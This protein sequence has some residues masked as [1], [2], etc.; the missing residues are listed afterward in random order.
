MK[1]AALIVNRNKD[2]ELIVAGRIRETLEAGGCTCVLQ[3][4]LPESPDLTFPL[5]ADAECVIVLGGD[6]TLL[7]AARSAR[8]FDLPLLGV[9]LG[10]LGYLAEVERNSIDTAL[11]RLL[12]GDYTIEE[13]MMLSGRL[14]DGH[15]ENAL[16]D[17]VITRSGSL[18]IV[19]L[20]VH[21]NGQLLN[22]Y[23]ADGVILSTPTG[24][25]AYNLSAG[26]PIVEPQARIILLTPISPHTLTNR[27]IVL[28]PE[29]VIRVEIG[30]G[31]DGAELTVEVNFDGNLTCPMRTGESLEIARSQAVTRIIRL[32]QVGFLEVLRRKLV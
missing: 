18:Q 1:K 3:E 4:P 20:L 5:P 25:T 30:E 6:G 14:H 26:G 9:N 7:Q 28:S 16:N 17:I 2:P 19:K 24:S 12:V 15:T 32:E 27:S 31:R 8:L 23:E 10:T 13:R 29:D 11:H 22:L 21:V